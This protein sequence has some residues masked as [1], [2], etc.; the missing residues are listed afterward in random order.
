VFEETCTATKSAKTQKWYVYSFTGGALKM[1]EWKT[2]E[3]KN[4]EQL[5]GVEN[6]GVDSRGIATDEFSR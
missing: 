5:A 4:R 1:R 3:W 2:Q 6:T